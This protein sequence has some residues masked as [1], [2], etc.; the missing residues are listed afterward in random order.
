MNVV[1]VAIL[2]GFYVV[3]MMQAQTVDGKGNL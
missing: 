2:R 3:V 1:E